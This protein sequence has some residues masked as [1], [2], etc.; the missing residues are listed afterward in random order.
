MKHDGLVTKLETVALDRLM[1]FHIQI[2]KEGDIIHTG[3][4]LRKLLAKDLGSDQSF[5]DV[6]EILRPVSAASIEG[7]RA[8]A[9]MPIKLRLRT[10]AETLRAVVV[11]TGSGVLL[12][13]SF[14]I[15]LVDAVRRYGLTNDDF[16]PTEL[17][18]EL[19][20]LAEAKSAA[21]DE[22]RRLNSRLADARNAAEVN[23]NTDM[24][25]GL[26]NRRALLET[27][28]RL[29]QRHSEFALMHVDLDFFKDVNDS[30]GHAA[31]DHVLTRVGEILNSVVRSSDVVARVGGD[32]F[33]L[34]LHRVTDPGEINGLA[35]R[36]I[37]KL[38]VPMN[39]KGADCR[40]SASIG[41]TVSTHYDVIDGDRMLRDA[42]AALYASKRQGR[43]R[44][45]IV[46]RED[47]ENEV[48]AAVLEPEA[49]SSCPAPR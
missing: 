24:L 15:S 39:F 11:P 4:T 18:I 20:F 13:M 36:L 12:N 42:D 26:S 49:P 29:V 32:E 47:V 37:A 30:L 27:L 6:F 40:I 43:A 8:H 1:P 14:G 7:L 3:P 10:R 38:E 9:H 34:I 35:Q 2:G 33:V 25:T 44:A 45:T 16:A 41:T 31:G 28:D 5:F 22:S 48:F 17:A 19:L 46:S 23:A 21:Y